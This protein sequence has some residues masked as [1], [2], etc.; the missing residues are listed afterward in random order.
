MLTKERMLVS[1]Y[2]EYAQKDAQENSPPM[3]KNALTFN[4]Y[5]YLMGYIGWSLKN[6]PIFVD[7]QTSNMDTSVGPTPRILVA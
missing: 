7:T 2:K 5:K 1:A 4:P 3:N 6:P